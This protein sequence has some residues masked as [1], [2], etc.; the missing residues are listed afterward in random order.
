MSIVAQIN[1]QKRPVVELG[2]RGPVVVDIQKALAKAGYYKFQIDDKYGIKTD[3]AVRA[4]QTDNHIS[5]DGDVGAVT[6]GLLDKLLGI[7]TSIEIPVVKKSAAV[8]TF[9]YQNEYAVL[10]QSIQLKPNRLKEIDR[11]IDKL[12]DPVR[13]KEYLKLYEATGVPP[14]V[15]AV[16][17]ERECGGNL[18]GVLH[19][20]ELII[21]TGRK[22]RLVPAGRGPFSTFYA[23]GIDAFKKE[24]LDTFDWHAGG[25]ARCAYALEKFN[26][27][28]YRRHGIKSPYLWAATNHYTCGKFVRDGVF[29]AST[30][31]SQLGGMAI[32][33]RM[34]NLD[35]S[36]KF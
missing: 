32:L 12:R 24:G 7:E 13:W 9:P 3:A 18:K 27:F 2:A 31:D 23:A 14:Q 10:W 15:T 1:A 4:F 33:R 17:H 21:G 5:V 20:G 16:I 22:T 35:L 11:V 29:N 6:G 36:L 26:G 25:A 34:M 30:V 19:N 28:G 8:Q